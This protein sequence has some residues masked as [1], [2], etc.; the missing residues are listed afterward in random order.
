MWYNNGPIKYMA[1]EVKKMPGKIYECKDCGR[2][3]RVY[4]EEKKESK[5][6]SC[7]STNTALKQAQP[8]P[9][10]LLANRA[11]GSG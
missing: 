2:A 11:S 4:E 5:C 1:E 7:E 6:P 10:W 8:L 9:S 3:F